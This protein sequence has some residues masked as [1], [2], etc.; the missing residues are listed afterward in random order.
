MEV[1][2][3]GQEQNQHG[4]F[5]T[6]IQNEW[7]L[8]PAF[9][10]T[11][12]NRSPA[13]TS[14]DNVDDGNDDDDDDLQF[15]RRY[16]YFSPKKN[17]QKLTWKKLSQTKWGA[18]AESSTAQHLREKIN[19]NENTLCSTPWPGQPLNAVTRILNSFK[20]VNGAA[21]NKK[22][23]QS[24]ADVEVTPFAKLSSYKR[25]S[26]KTIKFPSN[27]SRISSIDVKELIF[28]TLK[29]ASFECWP[30]LQ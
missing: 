29:R 16:R 10:L 9:C 1:E 25:F 22:L 13:M 6:F 3:G 27:S 30:L 21:R 12:G 28:F 11:F 26:P 4:W 17:P 15:W 5:S 23:S 8:I 24:C 2:G 19:R 7:F 18:V 14:R 20:T